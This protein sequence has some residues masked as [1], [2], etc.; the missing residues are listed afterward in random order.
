[1]SGCLCWTP[2][3]ANENLIREREF[4]IH[5]GA[6]RLFSFIWSKRERDSCKKKRVRTSVGTHCFIC[7][8]SP[9]ILMLLLSRLTLLLLTLTPHI[10]AGSRGGIESKCFIQSWLL[11]SACCFCLVDALLRTANPMASK[12][13]RFC[14]WSPGRPKAP[15]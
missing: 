4:A 7:C 1:M 14:P 9:H 11:L 10:R 12:P 5:S 13:K 6:A 3:R 15:P 2:C 8:I